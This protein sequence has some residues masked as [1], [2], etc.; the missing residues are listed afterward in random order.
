MGSEQEKAG[1]EDVGAQ[2]G[3][4]S[5]EG[6][7]ADT[8]IGQDAEGLRSQLEEERSK[9]ERCLTNWQRA[10][11]DLANFK[12]R[13]EQEKADLIKYANASVIGKILPVLDDFERAIGAIPEDAGSA[14]WV[15]G[16]KLIDRK[17]RN[18]LEQEGVT[19]IEAL[20]QE[21]DP[22]VH[23][24]VMREE[25]EGDLDVVVEEFQKGYKLN[26][27][28]IRPTMVKVGRRSSKSQ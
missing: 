10:E 11:A 12:R 4:P 18:L 22:H 25:G 20:G 8:S 19:P 23:E 27:R 24:A 5:V 13:T 9:A 3:E 28:V 7:A 15:D 17:L 6:S 1:A 26:D 16:I 2:E 21:F 14:G